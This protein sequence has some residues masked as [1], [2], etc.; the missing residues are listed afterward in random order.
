[1]RNGNNGRSCTDCQH[2]DSRFEGIFASLDADALRDLDHARISH[3]YA[4]GQMLFL[5]GSA[6]TG[7][8]C[9]R[10]G[11]VKVSRSAPRDRQYVVY[12]AGP[13]AVV[14]LEAVFSG[15]EYST[16][17]A[18]IEDGTVCHI[19]REPL[20]RIIDEN[21]HLTRSVLRLLA[22]QLLDSE[23]ER[24]ELSSADVRQRVAMRLLRLAQK[25]GVSDESG[26]VVSLNLTREDLASMVGSTPE[27]AI[28]QLSELRSKGIIATSG[29]SIRI[30]DVE[31]L[32]RIA[33]T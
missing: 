28:R 29:R 33:R 25:H 15:R 2:C 31:R 12:L 24:S 19:A 14:G 32:Q 20:L 6:C 30:C 13:G 5:E 11:L 8:F 17:A 1:M 9:V 3:S 22:V 26:V 16:S 4:R 10:S 23:S 21:P 27:T 18:M 7:V